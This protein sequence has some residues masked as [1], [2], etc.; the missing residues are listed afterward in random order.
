MKPQYQKLKAKR[1]TKPLE[2]SEGFTLAD[3]TIASAIF[4]GVLIV[5]LGAFIAMG[6]IYFRGSLEAKSQEVS[7]GVLDEITR[8][9]ST[10]A[11]EVKG[12]ITQSGSDWEAYCIAG[13]KYSFLRGKQLDRNIPPRSQK[14]DRA[15]IKSIVIEIDS[16]G[17]PVLNSTT[18]RPQPAGT[19][20]NTGPG[21]DEVGPGIEL[22]DYQMRIH[23]FSITS[24]GRHHVIKLDILYGGDPDVPARENEVFEFS[25]ENN[26]V[27]DSQTRCELT[28]TF[29]FIT[30]SEREVYQSVSK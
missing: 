1:P 6:R 10:T 30:R 17:N 19:C 3:V 13:V 26:P 18:N 25:D 9:I 24:Y 15:F 29:C 14:V 2:N 5:C 20:D 16:N 12:P 21:P 22:L 8:T 28:E 7:R 11:V 23:D 27:F 4:A